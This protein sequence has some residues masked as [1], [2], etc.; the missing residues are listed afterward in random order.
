MNIDLLIPHNVSEAANAKEEVNNRLDNP[1]N[2][3]GCFHF[4]GTHSTAIA[5]DDKT[6]P[7]PN[8]YLLPPILK[9]IEE[10]GIPSNKITKIIA[11]GTL[12]PMIPGEYN[13]IIHNSI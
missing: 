3:F 10:I 12:V 6:R 1:L 9:R 11:S 8:E 7:I 5:I 2:Q 13:K 4:I